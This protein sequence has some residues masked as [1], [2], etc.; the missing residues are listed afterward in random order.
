MVFITVTLQMRFIITGAEL[1]G[2][3]VV[4]IEF[5]AME[6]LVFDDTVT[7]MTAHRMYFIKHKK[8]TP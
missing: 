8:L 3:P 5:L 4:R 1:S 6:E 7:L 2:M